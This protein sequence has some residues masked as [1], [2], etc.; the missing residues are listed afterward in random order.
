MPLV[1]RKSITVARGLRDHRWANSF[2]VPL[3]LLQQQVS[4]F[5]ELWTRLGVITLTEGTADS[6]VWRWTADGS[7]SARSAY[8]IQFAGLYNASVIPADAI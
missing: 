1:K 4:E 5:V 2:W 3:P 6:I 7:Y 8:N